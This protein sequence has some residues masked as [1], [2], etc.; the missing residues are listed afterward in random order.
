MLSILLVCCLLHLAARQDAQWFV[1]FVVVSSPPKGGEV[2]VC[3][4]I[5]VGAIGTA[6]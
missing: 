6:I 4:E 2:L 1:G 3:R 5:D